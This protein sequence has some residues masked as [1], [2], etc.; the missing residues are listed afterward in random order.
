[1]ANSGQDLNS[2]KIMTIKPT[3]IVGIPAFNEEGNIAE[4]IKSVLTQ[5]QTDFVLEKIIVISDGSTDK[6]EE[7]VRNFTDSKVK[8][9]AD[10]VRKGQQIRQNE[11]IEQSEADVLVLLNADIMLADREFLSLLIK[12]IVQDPNV[13]MVSAHMT[14]LSPEN[15]F[16]KIVNYSVALKE[17]IASALENGNNIYFC[18]GRVRAFSKR[19]VQKLQW[20][21]V[22]SEDAYS[23]L[24]C[25]QSG[26]KFFYQQHAH[27]YF[28]S[29][30]NLN[31]HIKQ[32]GRFLQG[33]K[34]L[35]QFVSKEVV[36]REHNIPLKI[37]FRKIV[38][39]LI[40]NPIL[41]IGYCFIACITLAA[42]MVKTYALVKWDQSKSSKKMR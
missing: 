5:D 33:Q 17:E 32:S 22:V 14:P 10:G 6:T 42:S 23:Y 40:R 12:P 36:D 9:I 16:E 34:N 25:K 29:P 37:F 26:Y 28:R 18:H 31:D 24:I 30:Q 38:K 3:V 19:F 35:Y 21:D 20:P 4:L 1:M 13:G 27:F 15:Y 8:L 41:F 11:I 2:A 7:Y 39:Y